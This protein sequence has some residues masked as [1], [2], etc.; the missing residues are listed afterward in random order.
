MICGFSRGVKSANQRS[1]FTLI[2]LLVVI[3]MTSLILA[4]LLPALRKAR[5]ITKR[6]ACQN[7]LKQLAFAWNIYLD[8]H[9]GRFYQGMNANFQYG[10]WKGQKGWS[11]RPL[12]RYFNLPG[13]M[14][15]PAGAEIFFCPGDRGGFPPGHSVR[16]KVYRVAG[17]SYQTNILLIG[18]PQIG[19][20][21]GRLEE[22]HNEIN[23][24]LPSVN[25]KHVAN[26]SRLLLIG[27]YGWVNQA[28]PSPHPRE[29]WKKLQEWHGR[30]DSHNL[31]FL[32]CHV[33]FLKLRKG[34]YVTDEYCVLPF[35]DLY[36][37][38]RKAQ[39]EEKP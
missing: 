37:L 14:N 4:I 31:A 2:E 7:N 18:Y 17:T 29:D 13:D 30:E 39:E 26:P 23:K 32:D 1:G 11:P 25:R 24:R 28:R 35:K 34:Y 9:N 6:I 36:N 22:L 19:V 8:D 33:R 38:A 12:N 10:G 27:D 20:P 16:E 5:M 15:E 21:K 3:A